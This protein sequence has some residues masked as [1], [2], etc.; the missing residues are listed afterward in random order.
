MPLFKINSAGVFNA[1][2]LPIYDSRQSYIGNYERGRDALIMPE[3]DDIHG[4]GPK[5]LIGKR[6]LPLD[7]PAANDTRR[8]LGLLESLTIGQQV[9]DNLEEVLPR[10]MSG[11]LKDLDHRIDAWTRRSAVRWTAENRTMLQA[12]CLAGGYALRRSGLLY[13][14]TDAPSARD[15]SIEL[16]S[17]GLGYVADL[18]GFAVASTEGNIT[19]DAVVSGRDYELAVLPYPAVD[20]DAEHSAVLIQESAK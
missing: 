3:H 9:A 12:A 13:A 7:E 17:N 6:E 20:A 10:V 8:W 4:R 19:V 1:A 14:L 5:R 11:H 18:A 16:R 2:G 15:N